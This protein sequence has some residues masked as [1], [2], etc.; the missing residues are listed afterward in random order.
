MKYEKKTDITF[1]ITNNNY[2]FF[3]FQRDNKNLASRLSRGKSLRNGKRGFLEF[4]LLSGCGGGAYW[5]GFGGGGAYAAI[6]FC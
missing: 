3:P 4:S 6:A 1:R 5:G 2:N